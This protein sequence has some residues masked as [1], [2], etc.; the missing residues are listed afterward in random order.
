ML[1]TPQAERQQALIDQAQEAV[2][3]LGEPQVVQLAT[4]EGTLI[5]FAAGKQSGR[6]SRQPA[7]GFAPVDAQTAQAVAAATVESAVS[8][9][10]Q[11]TVAF[12]AQ[13]R[14]QQQQLA[15]IGVTV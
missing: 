14:Q 5:A 11:V 9:P 4:P 13:Q 1:S 6:L 12:A 15:P 7:A 8:V 2:D 10:Q 3:W